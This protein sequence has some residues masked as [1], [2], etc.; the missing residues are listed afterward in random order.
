MRGVF[1]VPSYVL[2]I[3]LSDQEKQRETENEGMSTH[4][5]LINKVLFRC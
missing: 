3:K 1:E 2:N 5:Y 4:E